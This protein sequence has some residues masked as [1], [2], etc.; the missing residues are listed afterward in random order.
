M[1]TYSYVYSDDKKFDDFSLTLEVRNS[2]N[3]VLT[4]KTSGA[5]IKFSE[6]NEGLDYFTYI[7][8]R[9]CVNRGKRKY[10]IKSN[11]NAVMVTINSGTKPESKD[12]DKDEM[13]KDLALMLSTIA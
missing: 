7:I 8:D 10:M 5:N 13:S 3:A 4:A 6:L 12:Y 1:R 11:N 2:G 9:L